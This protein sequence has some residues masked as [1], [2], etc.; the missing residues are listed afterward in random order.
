MIKAYGFSHIGYFP[1]LCWG[2][3]AYV[4]KIQYSKVK[5]KFCVYKWI[6]STSAVFS[7]MDNGCKKFHFFGYFNVKDY[8]V[9]F[10]RKMTPE[11]Y[12]DISQ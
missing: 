9:S 1:C 8:W 11:T 12:K 5:H 6:D 2:T 4:L 7:N 3:K 10:D